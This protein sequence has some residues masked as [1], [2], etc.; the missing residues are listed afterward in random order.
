MI[1]L[2]FHNFLKDNCFL[3][4]WLSW[5]W[6]CSY[7]VHIFQL[8]CIFR[9]I[10]LA[11]SEL[12]S[13]RLGLCLGEM[14]MPYYSLEGEVSLIYLLLW[15]IYPPKSWPFFHHKSFGFFTICFVKNVYQAW[16][17]FF[18]LFVCLND[19]SQIGD[20]CVLLSF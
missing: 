11:L 17:H 20:I 2:A 6:V 19:Y 3:Y 1:Y 15:I 5:A 4:P 9:E 10:I 14:R 8:L 13:P 12:L 18:H 7:H 16:N